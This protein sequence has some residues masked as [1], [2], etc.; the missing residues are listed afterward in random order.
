MSESL[1]KTNEIVKQ[2]EK[3]NEIVKLSKDSDLLITN[4]PERQEGVDAES[5]L[6]F[7]ES[8]T[9]GMDRCLF[10]GNPGVEVLT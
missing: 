2:A 3:L 7:M 10:I 6:G 8:L 4:L 5:Y 9:Q 1:L